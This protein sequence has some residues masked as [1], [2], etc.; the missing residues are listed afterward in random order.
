MKA[1]FFLLFCFV[2]FNL[3]GQEDNVS[4]KHL[5]SNNGLS[6][7]NVNCIFQ[8]F[9]GFIWVGTSEG[10]N[11]FDGY[12]FQVFKNDP[13]DTNSLWSNYIYS[14]YQ[15]KKGQLW[16]GTSRGIN[17]YN[18]ATNTFIRNPKLSGQKILG[19][20]Q[21]ENE[22]LIIAS[23]NLHVLYK[24]NNE[25]V[26][27]YPQDNNKKSISSG[28][29]SRLYVDRKN[30][31]WVCTHNGLNLFE[32]K[33]R[34]FKQFTSDGSGNSINSNNVRSVVV[35]SN[36]VIWVGTTKGLN[37]I[38]WLDYNRDSML[39]RSYEYNPDDEHSISEGTVTDL[40]C[41]EQ[42]NLWVGTRNGGIN[43]LKLDGKYSPPYI[44]SHY[45]YNKNATKGINNNSIN[46]IYG[47][48][49]GNIWIGT[50]AGGINL[51]NKQPKKFQLVNDNPSPLK[52]INNNQVNTFLE[53]G[54]F[55]WIGTEG[56]L[57]RYNKKTKTYKNFTHEKNN[58]SSIGANAVWSIKKNKSGTL[59]IGTWGGGI[60][61]FDIRK[62][63]FTRY[64]SSPIAPNSI[65]S[66][67][68]FSI[69]ADMKGN[70]WLG[71]MGGGLNFFNVEH[72][73]F[74]NYTLDNSQIASNYVEDIIENGAGELILANVNGVVVFDKQSQMIKPYVLP[75]P[76]P[77]DIN[78]LNVWELFVDSKKNLWLGTEAGLFAVDSS[79]KKYKN[80]TIVDGLPNN[81]I[82][83][84]LEDK[85]GNLWLGTNGGL[86]KFIKGTRL[87][88]KPVFNNYT[89]QDGLQGNEFIRRSC[90]QTKNGM[91]YFGGLN[92]Y[93]FFHPD[94]IH[95]NS[96]SSKVIIT[97][98]LLFNK[99]VEA[100]TE[101]SPLKKHISETKEIVLNAEQT[102]FGF[103]FVS[104]DF[105]SPNNQKY[106]YKLKGFD[107][108]WNHIE[109]QREAS[110]TSMRPG[111][112]EFLVKVSNRDGIWNETFASVQIVIQ[113]PF[114]QTT[115]AFIIYGSLFILVLF[116]YQRYTIIKINTKNKLE[117]EHLE[118]TKQEEINQAKLHF[119]TN[120]SHE[121]RT[122]LTLI[123]APVENVLK[124]QKLPKGA[125]DELKLAQ[126]NIKRL[127]NL[128]NQLLD[129][130]KVDT[131]SANL[132]VSYGNI[133]E[134]ITSIINA[135]KYQ[136]S[137]NSIKFNFKN[138]KKE[139]FAW[140]DYEKITSVLYNLISNA[141]KY[142]I[143]SCCIDIE[144]NMLKKP[145][146]TEKTKLWGSI[147]KKKA[148]EV[149]FIEIKITDK[150]KGIPKNQ[151][152]K[153]FD[154][155]YQIPENKLSKVKGTGI[156]L[157]ICKHYIELHYGKIWAESEVG[158]GSSFIF[159]IP[160]GNS[161]LKTEQIIREDKRFQYCEGINE[162]VE[163]EQFVEQKNGVYKNTLSKESNNND[164]LVVLLVEDNAD[165]I[166]YLGNSLKNDYRILK[167]PNGMVG[168]EL[169]H[170]HNPD[171][172][173]TDLMMPELDGV[174]MTKKLKKD[175]STSHIPVIMLT[176][177]AYDEN[178]IEG[179]ESGAEAYIP[180]PFKVELLKAYIITI[181]D[182]RKK[183]QE[184]YTQQ[185]FVEPC[186]ITINNTDKEFLKRLI[187]VVEE[188]ISNTEYNVN[189]LSEAMNM[190]Y[191]T[192]SRKVKALTN[193]TVNEFI[194][195]LRLKRAA[196]I[197][198]EGKI[199]IAEVST[200]AGFSDPSYF[201]RCFRV[202]FGVSPTEYLQ[203]K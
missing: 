148:K 47:D 90:M 166:A 106:A 36:D 29:I 59:W 145:L 186:E 193:Q 151:L 167:A 155:Y 104:I 190:S 118:Y 146:I 51:Y 158:K 9:Q 46:C 16:I 170:E 195:I 173:I 112:Y 180:K 123:N 19:I 31:I 94:S 117:I 93:N 163:Q 187:E 78:S 122:P 120:L 133:T 95:I 194:K 65:N 13:R 144:I 7:S 192:L 107:T 149:D 124:H 127:L 156:G 43:I 54:D 85:K 96:Q 105:Q 138:E 14:I 92:G 139:I 71:T 160:T 79:Q 57:N 201:G 48:K 153:I 181:L 142:S 101:N 129:F 98:F 77:I 172:I 73:I 162:R 178:K 152:D 176:A 69:E 171:I 32:H 53:D 24:I 8:D 84:I 68:I 137:S 164:K 67:N 80:Y 191:R 40:H 113:P 115:W 62:E 125:K 35:D 34:I 157:N 55:I 116:F 56:G 44:F 18:K 140:F 83:S 196:F 150:G 23:K 86:A 76:N 75:G 3:H 25:Y 99:I 70:L 52:S 200:L 184:K 91:M 135:F 49:E 179:I 159:Q 17:V 26:E 131:N 87:P 89:I 74:T 39:V 182:S 10:L 130:R 12:H 82:K 22:N 165:L 126:I 121:I 41:D 168:L 119:F 6:A 110:Y 11:K 100:G 114:W 141:V 203:E 20:I 72:E 30:R 108:E 33:K 175:L 154:R 177:K 63:N 88:S 174:E 15:D 188:N 58:A 2:S 189:E 143:G 161:H 197:L 27:Y 1:P 66:N 198:K 60:N 169:A 4:F 42:N 5:T 28:N 21:D 185:L 202:H 61:L 109:N 134:L 38:H 103:K 128:V 50:Y 81:S 64:K 136:K 45:K 147:F 102:S 97:D 132:K 111:K 183:L 199:P 37:E